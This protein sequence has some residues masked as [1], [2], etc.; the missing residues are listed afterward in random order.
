MRLKI[1][2]FVIAVSMILAVAPQPARVNAQA[3]KDG[4]LPER[5]EINQKFKLSPGARVEISTIAGPVDIETTSSD[6]A[7]VHIVRSAQTRADLECYKTIVEQ[8][9]TSLVIRH[10]QS[11]STVRDHQRVK[12]T[13]PRAIELSLKNIAGHV[14][15]GAVNGML[16]LDSIAGQV[17]LAQVQT[18]QIDSLAGGLSIGIAEPGDQGIRISS[19]AGGVD[20]SVLAGVNA[21][22]RV[23]NVMGQIENELPDASVTKTGHSRFQVLIGSGGK[24]I[25]VSNVMGGIKIHR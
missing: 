21:D 10:E 2:N 7:E 4:D 23:G 8:T 17:T 5:E 12:L 9:A 6:L 11:C 19:I 25:S 24:S 20:L 13:L 22:L 14:N 18:A 15:I 3:Q 1:T 16:R